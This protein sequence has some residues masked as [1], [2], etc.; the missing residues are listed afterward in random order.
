MFKIHSIIESTE[1][2]ALRWK[3]IENKVRG[4]LVQMNTIIPGE[5]GEKDTISTKLRNLYKGNNCG[6]R[7]PRR[8]LE[9]KRFLETKIGKPHR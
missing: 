7:S 2:Q 1:N 6:N 5:K 3:A 4:E 9:H 8:K